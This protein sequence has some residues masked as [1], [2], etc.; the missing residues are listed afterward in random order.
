MELRLVI[1]GKAS[2]A[3]TTV[4]RLTY[5]NLGTSFL[6]STARMLN[7]PGPGCILYC[8]AWE[9]E[10]RDNSR[11]RTGEIDDASF[12][13]RRRDMQPEGRELNLPRK[14]PL[15]PSERG[16]GRKHT[17]DTKDVFAFQVR[18]SRCRERRS[19]VPRRTAFARARRAPPA[20]SCRAPRSEKEQGEAHYITR[21]QKQGGR[22][23][24][25]SYSW[26]RGRFCVLGW[27]LVRLG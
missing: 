1:R 26:G 21:P 6:R 16:S 19:R 2:S 4:W 5:L 10:L 9:T 7:C 23:I 13:R 27:R 24:I 17:F 3:E 25:D 8:H 12:I 14:T 18:R 20:D 22:R 15:R 11:G